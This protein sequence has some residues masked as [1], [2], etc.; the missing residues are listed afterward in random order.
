[1]KKVGFL[2]FLAALVVGFIAA[3]G[4]SFGRL[5]ER[6]FNFSFNFTGERGSGNVAAE[7]R[8]L[9]DFKTV[10][11]SGV[12]QVEATAQKDYAVTVEADDNLLPMIQTRV[13]GG[14]LKIDS[15][16]R[17]SPKNPMK[18]IISAPDIEG[19]DASGAANIVLNSLK[20][21][22]FRIESSGAAKVNASGVTNKLV[23][24]VS[25]A[26]KID[27][28][29]LT[30]TSAN[31]ESS[32]ASQVSVNVTDTL[33]TDASG[34]SKIIYSGSPRELVTKKSGAASVSARQ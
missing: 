22:E 18:I 4:S 13:E 11:V 2:I 16:G 10:D 24:D 17:L 8:D 6:P 26:T 15:D 29:G 12:F 27:A 9:R 19:L 14:V 21:E 1:M 7:T 34:A 28:A 32:G 30:A 3:S 25:G 20:N 33:R 23:V 31:V 5:C